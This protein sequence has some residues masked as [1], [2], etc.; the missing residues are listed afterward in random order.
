[1][2]RK[3]ISILLILSM[4]FTI[5]PGVS[6]VNADAAKLKLGD[7]IHFGSYL[8]EPILWQVVNINK[9]GSYEILSDRILTIRAFNGKGYEPKGRTD[10]MR[11]GWGSNNWEESTLRQWLNSD[12][13]V[14]QYK[15]IKPDKDH[16]NNMAYDTEPGFL[17]GFTAKEKE[18][19]VPVKRMT[20]LANI[21]APMK[22][23]GNWPSDGNP[24]GIRKG[25]QYHRKL[26]DKV[27]IPDLL[28]LTDYL[29]KKGLEIRKKPTENAVSTS[30]LAHMYNS[31]SYAYY[32]IRT[33]Y[34]MSYQ[35]MFV[36]QNGS[37]MQGPVLNAGGIV[38]M[39]TLNKN[40]TPAAGSG[41]ADS[42]YTLS[43][44][45]TAANNSS[46][47]VT[48][49]T[50]PAAPAA[51]QAG[52]TGANGTGGTAPAAASTPAVSVTGKELKVTRI[53]KIASAEKWTLNSEY[54]NNDLSN[55]I[56]ENGK[57]IAVGNY[58]QVRI[59]ADGDNWTSA[60]TGSLAGLKGI[61]FGNG[62]YV[63]VGE[64]GF[65]SWSSDLAKWNKVAV[66]GLAADILSITYGNS[67]FAALTENGV[68]YTSSDG[69]AWSKGVT[70]TD[71]KNRSYI[72]RVKFVNGR[73]YA[74]G[75][76]SILYSADAVKWTQATI[77]ANYSFDGK[78]YKGSEWGTYDIAYGNNTLIASGSGGYLVSKDG[79]SNWTLKYLTAGKS[80][81]MNAVVYGNNG[82]VILGT[83][84]AMGLM[85]TTDG[86]IYRA[87]NEGNPKL[88][89]EQ[90]ETTDLSYYIM[91]SAVYG[92]EGFVAV[93]SGI[94]TSKD[95]KGFE[96]SSDVRTA[97][98]TISY[99]N[100]KYF[101]AANNRLNV[102]ESNGKNTQC[103]MPFVY[104]FSGIRK[105]VYANGS[106]VAV[107]DEQSIFHSKDG[108]QWSRI[109]LGLPAAKSTLELP[110][111]NGV[112]YKA[113][114]FI[115][116][117]T[118]NNLYTSADGL[119]WNIKSLGSQYEDL[120]I[121][122]EI[123]NK[124][125]IHGMVN[126]GVYP[127]GVLMLSED[128]VNWTEQKL[129]HF[130]TISDIAYGGGKYVVTGWS[131]TGDF[132]AVSSNLKDWETYS[133]K[134]AI[135]KDEKDLPLDL[136]WLYGVQ[137]YKGRF[138]AAGHGVS[139]KNTGSDFSSGLIITSEDGV[140]WSLCQ[141]EINIGI[142]QL[143]DLNNR[144]LAISNAGF[145]FIKD[146]EKLFE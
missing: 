142:S 117:D 1:M 85:Q 96:L 19:I 64:Q 53:E 33:P 13:T 79:G 129:E 136:V 74:L 15:Y 24:E 69:K 107:G 47:A 144:L 44:M 14:V 108:Y 115:A 71:R 11:T 55:V 78:E 28:E 126:A 61:A 52:S 89:P 51:P 128:G 103:V 56:Y 137:Y 116:V 9:D 23:G 37:I 110:A 114:K 60:Q 104:G 121:T 40:V 49:N 57:Y 63:T 25:D 84:H 70:I 67:K 29:I 86:V 5:I 17:N 39:L 6:F 102:I 59:S 27:V 72:R 93:G 3:Y 65:I 36:H 48:V 98:S 45:G 10:G 92:Q 12:E 109:N 87:D 22:D 141:P 146:L 38:P 7:Y 82:F 140:N 18:A 90:G 43:G 20:V 105:V 143:E 68:I 91:N 80:L 41:T 32:Y 76:Y 30:G 95:G 138:Y 54:A 113:G 94:V 139:G 21:D 135:A 106:Y 127:N 100:G 77:A 83:A 2:K 73:F 4:I 120:K 26:T 130:H 132:I 111:I 75:M 112:V 62:A 58:G 16:V 124:I 123:D 133:I 88:L 145:I 131:T 118:K 34:W 42:P 31:N 134:N 101:V 119:A 35:Q 125:I 97:S 122:I 81:T 46:N 66:N 50:A 99:A 8:N